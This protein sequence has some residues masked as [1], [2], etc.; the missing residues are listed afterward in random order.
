M[1]PRPEGRDDGLPKITPT[2]TQSVNR[3]LTAPIG[4]GPSI[5][6][7]KRWCGPPRVYKRGHYSMNGEFYGADVSKDHLDVACGGRVERIENT[8]KAIRGFVNKMPAGSVVAMEATNTYHQELA[9][10]AH[11]A[12]M[13]VYVVNPRVT[14]HYREVR[15][16]RGHTDRLD[17]L[18]LAGFIEREYEHLREYQPQSAG[19]RRLKTLLRRRSKLVATRVKLE[20]SMGE[21]KEVRQEVKGVID[22]LER[23]IKRI[24][25]LV[26][27]QLDGNQDRARIA[28]IAGVGRIVSSA[29]ICDLE[30]GSFRSADAFVAF[31]GLDPRPND[32]G[33]S[34]G[35]RR[36]SKQGQ[37]L[38]RMLLYNAAMSAVTTRAWA[39][40]YQSCLNRGLTKVQALVVIARKIARTAWSIYTHKTV[41]HPAR[42]C[43][44]P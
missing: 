35:R 29:L 16:L 26:E 10:T 27:E 1:L 21:I 8:K 42:L 15:N 5:V 31:Y 36:L 30:S 19:Q 41:F 9:D 18:T 44:A 2:H 20:Q 17:A 12:G 34:R 3:N 13:R 33:K 11:C 23:L 43:A 39:Q 4:R 24:E 38:G 25:T 6:A 28:Q 7:S 14:R 37:R 22:R 40:I 32:S